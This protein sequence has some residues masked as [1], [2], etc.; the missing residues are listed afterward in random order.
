MTKPK[1]VKVFITKYALTKGI[2][3]AEVEI[4]ET[5]GRYFAVDQGKWCIYYHKPDFHLTYKEAKARA[6]EMQRKKIASLKKQLARVQNLTF[7]EPK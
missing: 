4:K 5:D 2:F 3:T 7:E 1:K 6:E